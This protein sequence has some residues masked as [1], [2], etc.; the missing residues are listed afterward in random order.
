MKISLVRAELFHA[1]GPT[2][3]PTGRE[4]DRPTDTDRQTDRQAEITKL[5]VVFRNFPNAP[6]SVSF[7]FTEWN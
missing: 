4:T 6:K 5:I 3:R 2:D 7:R 1:N